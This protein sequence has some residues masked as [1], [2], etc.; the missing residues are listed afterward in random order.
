MTPFVRAEFQSF[1]EA[2]L[3]LLK[4]ALVHG[5]LSSP[6]GQPCL[7]LTMVNWSLTKPDRCN[8]DF[9]KTGL[10]GRQE[11]YSNYRDRE[12]EW[13]KSG[14]LSA[15]SAPSKFWEKIADKHGNIVSNYGDMVL[16]DAI[17]PGSATGFEHVVELL[18]RDR[19]SRQ[20]V[21]HYNQPKHY[22]PGNKD[23]PCTLTTQLWIR[24]GRLSMW[25][26][27]RS[28]DL[29]LGLPYDVPWHCWLL[30]EFCRKLS[31]EPGHF[32]HSIGSLHLYKKDEEYAR[33][34]IGK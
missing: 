10:P 24:G 27:Q 23:V 5:E 18:R 3:A 7:E 32:H 12:L 11:V 2:Y 19:D 9:T 28:C 25:T 34:V 22:W 4:Q 13:Y 1:H 30:G 33:A 20:A 6:R 16:F 21:Y 14:D 8:I 26:T 31:V 29:K 17:Y 15:R